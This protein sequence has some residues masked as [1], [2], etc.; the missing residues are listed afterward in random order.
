MTDSHLVN[1]RLKEADMER[2][3]RLFVGWWACVMLMIVVFAPA[4]HAQVNVPQYE[5]DRFWPKPLP[6]SWIL[7]GL[8]DVCVDAQDHV[9]ILNRQN[10]L[11][12]ELN[13]GSLAPSIIEFDVAGNVV[14]SWG[15]PELLDPR[16]HGCHFDADNNVWIASAPSGM[17][18]KYSHDGNLL[19]QIGTKGVLDSSDGTVSG[20]GLNSDAARFFTP[21]SVYVD[22]ENGDVYVADGEGRGTNR[23]IAVMDREG[24]FLRQ[25]Q[26]E[27]M[28]TVHCM[29]GASDGF[30]YVCNRENS[31][32]QVYDQSGSFIRNIEVPWRPYTP[33]VD[34]ET[35]REAGAATSLALSRDPNQ[36]RIYVV[37]QDNDR[38]QI[39]DRQTGRTLSTFGGG[40]GHSP[41]QFDQAHGIAVDSEGSVY[42]TE[43]RG[44]RI[45]RFTIVR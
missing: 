44:A 9:F 11:P 28:E 2:K 40:V 5:V 29:A 42:V 21:A 20:T 25:W 27:G 31:R 33:L 32:I 38:I 18:Q 30:I 26:P 10:V 34:G 35:R 39:I 16:L 41:G 13:S 4:L 24:R 43:N 3:R 19:F 7:G 1:S 22:P 36:E 15:D 37:N 23:R 17:V 12:E 8:A 6:D 14:N 45:Q